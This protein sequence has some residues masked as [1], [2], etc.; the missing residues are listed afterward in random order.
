MNLI[1]LQYFVEA[2]RCLNFS[3]AARN[4]YTSQPNLSKQIA[5]MEQELGYPLFSRTRRLVKLTPAG[6]YLYDHLKEV[7][8]QLVDAF[9]QARTLSRSGGT[10]SIG[11]LEGQEVNSRLLARLN[12]FSALYPKIEVELERNSFRNLRTGLESG[13]YD[14]VI[15]LDFDLEGMSGVVTRVFLPQ[16]AAIAINKSNP[17]SRVDSLTM[18]QL[19]DENFVVISP[20]ESPVGYERFLSQC[21]AAGF[22]PRVVRRPLSLESLLLCVEAGMGVALLDQNMRLEHSS[23]RTIPIPDSTVN[24]VLACLAGRQTPL[25]QSAFEVLSRELPEEAPSE[26]RQNGTA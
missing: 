1:R 18:E 9:E 19:R 17:R 6:Q 12:A 15:T 10:L 14:L 3:E 26:K 25:V 23:V 13:H 22:L 5:Q 21:A 2:A 8:A 16:P 7:P 11:I 20:E 24:V 4:L